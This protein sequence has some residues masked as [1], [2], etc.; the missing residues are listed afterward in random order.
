MIVSYSNDDEQV[1]L[2]KS[3]GFMSMVQIGRYG[4]GLQI[5]SPWPFHYH[6]IRFPLVEMLWGFNHLWKANPVVVK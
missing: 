2:L 1:I 6:L 4:S 3:E 5:G